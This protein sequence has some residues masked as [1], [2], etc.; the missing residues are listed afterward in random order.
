MISFFVDL[1]FSGNFSKIEAKEL[2]S[3]ANRVCPHSTGFLHTNR[4]SLD[5]SAT[6]LK[7]IK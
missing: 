7:G 2:A 6:L 5:S 3:A 4:T 1:K